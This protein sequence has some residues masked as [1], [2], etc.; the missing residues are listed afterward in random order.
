VKTINLLF[1]AFYLLAKITGFLFCHEQAVKWISSVSGV[2]SGWQSCNYR[3][4]INGVCKKFS[5]WHLFLEV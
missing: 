4:W 3:I 2:N 1:T 5:P